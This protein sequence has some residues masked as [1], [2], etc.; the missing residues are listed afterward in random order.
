[1][2][3]SACLHYGGPSLSS[4]H[5][6]RTAITTHAVTRRVW[7]TNS[8]PPSTSCGRTSCSSRPTSA[9]CASWIRGRALTRHHAPRAAAL[10]RIT[11]FPQLSPP[12]RPPGGAANGF[13]TRSNLRCWRQTRLRRLRHILP[14]TPLPPRHDGQLVCHG[15]GAAIP[16]CRSSSSARDRG[17]CIRRRRRRE[18]RHPTP[19]SDPATADPN[20]TCTGVHAPTQRGGNLTP[21]PSPD[22]TAADWLR[23]GAD[24]VTRP[25]E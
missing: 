6:F 11:L 1:M 2:I 3:V 22:R 5:D 15:A 8:S 10:D 25:M 9:R 17:T 16:T 13:S 20:H 14:Q 4:H 23:S 21:G 19:H 7:S 24:P 18:V 12:A